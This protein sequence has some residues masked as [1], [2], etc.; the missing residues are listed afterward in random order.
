MLIE[1][2]TL[3]LVMFTIYSMCGEKL[4]WEQEMVY[5]ELERRVAIYNDDSKSTG[6]K[7]VVKRFSKSEVG[8]ALVLAICTPLMARAHEHVKQ[9]GEIMFVDSSSSLDDFNNPMLYS[10]LHLQLEVCH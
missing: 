7:A 6:G 5:E 3:K 1:I 4:I 9:A 10:L 2:S 8:Y